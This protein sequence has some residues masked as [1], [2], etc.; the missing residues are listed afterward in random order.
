M[1]LPFFSVS[2]LPFFPSLTPLP[3]PSFS[4]LCS[5]PPFLLR[6]GWWKGKLALFWRLASGREEGRGARM[7]VQRPAPPTD[8][9]GAR[10]F[11]GG[12]RGL[13]AETAVSSDSHPD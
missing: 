4:H 7:P 1:V 3:P 8:N 2:L 6:P 5:L 11:T 9:R 13:Q 12:R 10:A